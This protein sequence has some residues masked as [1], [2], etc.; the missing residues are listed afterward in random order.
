MLPDLFR[1]LRK[2]QRFL[3]TFRNGEVYIEEIATKR[4]A[5]ARALQGSDQRA[6]PE[7]G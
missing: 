5:R 4:R 7:L 3:A 2:P 1:L 6:S